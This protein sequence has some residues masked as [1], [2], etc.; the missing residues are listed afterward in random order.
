MALSR[1]ATDG[2]INGWKHSHKVAQASWRGSG[3]RQNFGQVL[4]GGVKPSDQPVD[5]PALPN[6]PNADAWI[7][8]YEA[9]NG[10][11][12]VATFIATDAGKDWWRT[13]SVHEDGPL[14]ETAWELVPEVT[15][16]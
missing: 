5:A 16:P 14:V 13:V 6:N 10:Y 9:P 12:W 2:L 4:R 1:N 11:G 7:D 15:F 8:V 3:S